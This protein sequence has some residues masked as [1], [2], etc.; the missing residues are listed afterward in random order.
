MLTLAAATIP[1]LDPLP[2]PGPLGLMWGLLVLTFFIHILA[3]NFVLGG[4]LI[5]AVARIRGGPDADRL[6]RWLAK[7]MPTMVAG[8][9]TFGVAPLLFV[10][11]LYGRLFFS[12]AVLMAWF[13]FAVV[14][15]VIVA[16]YGTYLL[17]FRGEQLGKA[18]RAIAVVVA[19]IFVT[20][21]FI[22]SNNMTLMLRADR[23]LPMFIE[24]ARGVQLNL[25]DATL[26][27][28]FLHMLL[29]AV[30][31]AG[32]FVAIYGVANRKSDLAHARWAMRFG[33]FWFAGA[34]ALNI[35]TGVWWLGVLPREVMARFMGRSPIASLSLALGIIL[36]IASIGF[37][38][39]AIRSAVP[40]RSVSLAAWTTALTLI[41]MILARD[42]VRRGMFELANVQ[43]QTWIEPQW[44][45]IAVFGVL[46][47]AA[48]ASTAWMASL[49][50]REPRNPA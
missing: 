4:S 3:M 16:Y 18:A 7:M 28:R 9:V 35:L 48:F 6:V 13:W 10:Q 20:V 43:P 41:A 21:G 15:L 44:G 26:A 30:G 47:V 32:L 45:V 37:M 31:L 5:A 27:P 23:F 24:N 42:E 49:L 34:T 25:S 29:G 1:T 36:G 39:G 14:P 17:S 2:M 11:A 22:Y 50:L 38:L 19:L 40:E 33:A 8:T 46:L 12:S